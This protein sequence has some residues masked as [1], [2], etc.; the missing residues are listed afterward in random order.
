[1]KDESKGIAEQLEKKKPLLKN[2]DT[3][4]VVDVVAIFASLLVTSSIVICSFIYCQDIAS[5]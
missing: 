3:A 5:D 1:M 4:T 2:S